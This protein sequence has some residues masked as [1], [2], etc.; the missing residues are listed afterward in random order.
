MLTD[1]VNSKGGREDRDMCLMGNCSPHKILKRSTKSIIQKKYGK[2][3]LKCMLLKC[4]LQKVHVVFNISK[5][6]YGYLRIGFHQFPPY[7]LLDKNGTFWGILLSLI[8][9]GRVGGNLQ[10]V[11]LGSAIRGS[12]C[13]S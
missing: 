3:Y 12:Y 5:F 8:F 9:T 6:S 7:Y 4:T 2:C 10:K 11:Y 13:L 1:T